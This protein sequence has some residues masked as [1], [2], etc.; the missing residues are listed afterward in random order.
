LGSF[1][2]ATKIQILGFGIRIFSLSRKIR[3]K[4]Q[5]FEPRFADSSH[6]Y[7]KRVA[8]ERIGSDFGKGIV[9]DSESIH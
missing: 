7:K 2:L 3:K 9:A 5:I 4:I 8:G 1:Y 6:Q